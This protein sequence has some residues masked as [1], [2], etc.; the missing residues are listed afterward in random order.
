MCAKQKKIKH[1]VRRRVNER[2]ENFYEKRDDYSGGRTA[3]SGTSVSGVLLRSK[4]QWRPLAPPMTMVVRT[5]VYNNN[6]NNII[7]LPKGP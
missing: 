7:I 6:I 2:A 1:R 4:R 5:Y 3:E